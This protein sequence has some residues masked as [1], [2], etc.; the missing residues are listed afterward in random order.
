MNLP[1][2]QLSAD[3]A[4]CLAVMRTVAA[5]L[6]VGVQGARVKLDDGRTLKHRVRAFHLG[7]QIELLAGEELIL[8]DVEADYGKFTL[9]YI[10]P[11]RR[12]SLWREAIFTICIGGREHQGFNYPGSLTPEQTSL[13]NSG[14]LRDLLEVIGPRDGEEINVSQRLVRVFLLKPR[15]ERV[16]AV[17]QAVI[18][19][20]PHECESKKR[21]AD[22]PTE[23]HP[24]IP[25]VPKWAISDDQERWQKIRRCSRSTREKLVSTVIPLLPILNQYLDD[26]GENPDACEL[27]NVA[28]A[29]MEAQRLLSEDSHS[30]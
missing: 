10:N 16:M 7:H 22:L 13:I 9:F 20:M 2:E 29:A 6:G 12:H 14:A 25:L 19:L 4:D 3:G 24:L 26:F 11:R 17:I 18:G 15:A 5:S 30:K 1:L 28:Q 21:Y 8:V 23:L 27:G